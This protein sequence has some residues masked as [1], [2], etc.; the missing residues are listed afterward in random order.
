MRNL[1]PETWQKILQDEINSNYFR[2]L[3][4]F[5]DNEW[6]TETIFPPKEEIF[7]ALKLTPYSEVK[8]L[9]LGQDPY[10]DYNQAHGLAF[11][12]L[13]KQKLPP[14]LRNIYKELEN[15]LN[16]PPSSN[17][18]LESWAKQ[19]V[20][21][22]NT[23]LTVRAH[24]ANSHAKK[25]WETFTD[26]IIKKL[27]KKRE[28]VIFLLWGGNAA[29]KVPLIDSD[30][31]FIITA[32]HPS[33]LSAYRGFFG[34]QPFSEINKLLKKRNIPPINWEIPEDNSDIPL[35]DL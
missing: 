13:H 16:I 29:K 9:I 3:E 8:V 1:I 6:L 25:G 12:V 33:P 17:G 24:Q 18:N 21:L 31:H 30:K 4:K 26:A 14:S 7:T 20:L 15:D 10:H 34:S 28:P 35:F 19:G 27:N 32:P 23:V 11:S 22:I 2:D 5:L